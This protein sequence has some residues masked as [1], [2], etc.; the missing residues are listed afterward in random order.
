M[1]LALK[2]KP[3]HRHKKQTYVYQGERVGG[4]INQEVE[5]NIYTV[6]YMKQI[7][8]KNLLYSTGNSTKYSVIIYMGK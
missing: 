5:I 2:Q 1:N 7:T 3:T 4:E 6:L 8:I